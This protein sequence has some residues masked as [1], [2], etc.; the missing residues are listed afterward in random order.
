MVQCQRHAQYN[1]YATGNVVPIRY[2]L[3]HAGD[4]IG[5]TRADDGGLL[6]VAGAERVS[7]PDA[8]YEWRVLG[9]YDRS[10]GGVD[11][12]TLC[13]QLLDGTLG[14]VR[15]A[16]IV[17]LVPVALVAIAY[18]GGSLDDFSKWFKE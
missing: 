13:R 11:D 17:V 14:I 15:G 3:V 4:S 6:A 16:M 18:G 9:G 10:P 2:A 5:F 12:R 1:L 8:S 7:M